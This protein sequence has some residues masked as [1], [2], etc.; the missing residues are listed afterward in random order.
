MRIVKVEDEK[1]KQGKKNA[2]KEI[3]SVDDVID[4]YASPTPVARTVVVP[5][6]EGNVLPKCNV[7]GVPHRVILLSGRRR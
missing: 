3:M 1:I 4:R 2:E 6:V 5:K 7:V